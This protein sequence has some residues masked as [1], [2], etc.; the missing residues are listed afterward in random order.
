MCNEVD[1]NSHPTLRR[2]CAANSVT[3][4]AKF[5]VTC[6]EMFKIT[7]ALNDFGVG[8]KEGKRRGEEEG[9]DACSQVDS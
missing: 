3:M 2:I 4:A 1:R 8:E 9:E 5:I 7:H 6:T